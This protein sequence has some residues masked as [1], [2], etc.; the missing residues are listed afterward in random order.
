ME[1]IWRKGILWLKRRNGEMTGKMRKKGKEERR[2]GKT[3]IQI[4]E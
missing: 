4:V 2:A 3:F 1:R